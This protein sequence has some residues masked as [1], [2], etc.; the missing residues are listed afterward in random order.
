[1]AAPVSDGFVCAVFQCLVSAVYRHHLRSEH[2]HTF[3]IDMLALYI[4]GS[5]IDGAWHIH[6]CADCGCCHAVLSCAGF[7]Y[8]AC[9]AH[10]PCKENL[11]EGVVNLVC[12]GVVEVFSL[13]IEPASIPFGHASCVVEW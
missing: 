7:G 12:A 6:E 9:L 4:K 1:M 2:T 5:H 10:F 13:Q 3:H 11:S 8:D